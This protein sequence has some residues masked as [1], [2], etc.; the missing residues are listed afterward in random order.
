MEAEKVL[1]DYQPEPDEMEEDNSNYVTEEEAAD[2]ELSDDDDDEEEGFEK[3]TSYYHTRSLTIGEKE[4]PDVPYSHEF[5]S[6]SK[7]KRL[8]SRANMS[9]QLLKR[10]RLRVSKHSEARKAKQ[11]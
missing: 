3:R 10:I 11:Y 6:I 9:A 5:I 4:F 1:I 8:Q 2:G 7:R